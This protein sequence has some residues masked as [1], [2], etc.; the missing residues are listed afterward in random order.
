M[1]WSRGR[2]HGISPPFLTTAR[3]ALCLFL[4]ELHREV[5]R[6]CGDGAELGDEGLDLLLAA[7]LRGE[8]RLLDL[9]PT[10]L[11]EPEHEVVVF[12]VGLGGAQ[13][14]ACGGARAGAPRGRLAGHV[15]A[16][17]KELVAGLAE[18]LDALPE[19]LLEP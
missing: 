19:H 12:G 17:A 10:R 18:G 7:R 5:R 15:D 8:R 3:S 9:H 2:R 11:G 4:E 16:V 6:E 13:D 14:E 1:A